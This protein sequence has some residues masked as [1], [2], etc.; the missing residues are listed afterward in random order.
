VKTKN[1][2]ARL[3]LL[4]FAGFFLLHAAWAFAAP[5]DGPP[6]EKAH[7]LRA[8]AVGHG[9]LITDGWT[10]ETPRSLVRASCF[11]QHVEI[12]ADCQ[13]PPG[14]DEKMGPHTVGAASYNPIYYAVTGWPLAVWPNWTGILLA[15]LFTGA[16]MAAFLACAVVAA[17]HWIRRRAVLA[18]VLVSATPM[19]AHLGGSINPNG[20]EIAAAI[21]LFTGL[22]TVVLERPDVVN[23]RAVALIGVSAS[24]LVTLRAL[25]IVWF[26]LIVLAVLIGVSRSHLRALWRE[27]VVRSWLAV[28]AVAIAAAFTWNLV[29][30]PLSVVNGDMGMSTK[31]ILRFGL[32]DMWPNIANQLVGVMGWAEVLQPRLVYV[33]WFMAAGILILGGFVIGGRADKF[34]LLFL[35]FGTFVPLLLWELLRANDSGWF[36]Q[37]RY[38]LPG[39]VGLP[40][41]GAYV[42]GR[43]ELAPRVFRSLTRTLAVVLLPIQV[44]CLAYT[45]CRWQS[46]LAIL[47]PL[48]GSWLPPLG[49]EPPLI[50]GAL[51]VPV[52]FAVYWRASR[53]P[54][55]PEADEQSTFD[56]PE[57]DEPSRERVLATAR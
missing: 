40:I 31:E 13:K 39:A 22:I 18:G 47:N 7:A 9:E 24:V 57:D 36:N 30:S 45:M 49:P 21:A 27:R 52:L 53:V 23:R 43:S 3:W 25:G 29:A 34:R 42:I 6:D 48:K 14:G 35:F 4:A 10:Q 54:A 51:S 2:G 20:V 15:R 55:G 50:A 46:G 38:F 28:I 17:C 56:V 12:P 41:L 11:A 32:L 33:A 37:G 26:G 44:V 1:S 19:V 16:A 5:Y 8:A